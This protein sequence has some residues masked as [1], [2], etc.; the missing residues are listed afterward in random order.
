MDALKNLLNSIN[1]SSIPLLKIV[2]VVLVLTITQLMRRF[3]STILLNRIEALVAKTQ[4]DFDDELISILKPSLS[5]LILL[6]GFWIVQMICAENL[7]PQVNQ[8]ILATLHVLVMVI[9]GYVLYRCSSLLGQILANFILHTET[10]LDEILKP[11]LPKLFQAVAVVSVA[12]KLSGIF[13]GQSTGALIGLFGGAGITLGLLFKDLLYD[14]FCTIIIY[15]D[16]LYKEGDWIVTAEVNGFTQ[17]LKIGFRTT[18]LHLLKNGAIIKRPNSKMIEGELKNWSQN[19]GKTALWGINWILKLERISSQQI[20]QLC[21]SIRTIPASIEGMSANCMVRFLGI[22]GN[23]RQI[24]IIAFVADNNP[25]FYF[26]VEEQFNLAILALLER[27]EIDTLPYFV[28]LSS[29]LDVY[30]KAIAS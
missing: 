19:R 7:S 23:V 30:K 28:E 29:P 5:W 25:E 20:A 26:R 6:G 27:E 3:F 21:A 18:T 10:E 13:F 2:A 4:S 9:F 1:Y 24:E 11:L 15:T 22:D 12:I 14:W 8:T 17:V 16:Q